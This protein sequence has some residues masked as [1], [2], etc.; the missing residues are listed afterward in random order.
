MESG[1]VYS[2]V[3]IE[4]HKQASRVQGFDIPMDDTCVVKEFNHVPN[5]RGVISS[6]FKYLR[7]IEAMTITA[8]AFWLEGA[9]DWAR[10]AEVGMPCSTASGASVSRVVL[11]KYG[12]Y[13]GSLR[14]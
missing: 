1:A 8:T 7:L 4:V 2:E 12:E 10:A 14:R 9:G 11:P 6:D 5:P 13:G 3:L